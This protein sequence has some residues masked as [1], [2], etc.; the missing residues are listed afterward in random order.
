MKKERLTGAVLQKL[1]DTG[2]L[3]ITTVDAYLYLENTEKM[4]E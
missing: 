4:Q 1:H 3:I 2:T